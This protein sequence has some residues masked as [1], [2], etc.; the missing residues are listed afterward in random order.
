MPV[1]TITRTSDDKDFK[2]GTI[3]TDSVSII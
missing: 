2:L 1:N 3:D